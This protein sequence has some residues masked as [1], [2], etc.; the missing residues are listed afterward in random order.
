VLKSD[1]Y[2]SV[3]P[4]NGDNGRY[5]MFENCEVP[6][7][8]SCSPYFS[9]VYGASSA[10]DAVIERVIKDFK[11]NGEKGRDFGIVVFGM[12]RHIS[13][14]SVNNLNDKATNARRIQ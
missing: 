2:G 3:E 12:E 10:N 5:G 9:K 7:S 8:A 14:V 11:L 13:L 4:P 6:S 1:D